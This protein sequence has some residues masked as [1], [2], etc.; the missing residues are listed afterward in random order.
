MS[1]QILGTIRSNRAISPP[2]V[3]VVI[4]GVVRQK[5]QTMSHWHASRWTRLA[6][7]FAITTVALVPTSAVSGEERG[8][9]TFE[10][11]D[12]VSDV[13]GR[14]E[15]TDPN[16]VNA[17]GL[18]A[19]PATPI[20]VAD[21]GTDVS[22][23]YRGATVSESATSVL[24]LV[25]NIPNGA[26]TGTVFN[27]TTGF[28]VGR[29]DASA[30]ALFLFSS[31]NGSIDGWAPNVP[32]MASTE[33]QSAV[34][35]PEAVYKG[36]AIATTPSGPRLYAANFHAGTVDVFDSSFTPIHDP[37]AFVDRR[38][39]HDY[40]PFN[41]QEL[42]GRLYV[43]Y[44]QQS[45]DR[46]DDVAGAGHGFVD[47][48]DTSGK[49][50]KR[51]ARSGRLNSPWGLALAPDS[52]GRFSHALLVGNF[53]DG[54]INA[55][56]ADTGAWLGQL[57]DEDHKPITIDGLWALRIGNSAF[58]GTESLVF[59]AGPDDEKHGLL[60]LISAQPENG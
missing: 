17:W 3:A 19:G 53:G 45:D 2:I 32:S 6:A 33:A 20:W 55:Y 24:P 31:E 27:G 8:G 29:D 40:A 43:T 58:G 25:V 50:L 46:H 5:G 15:V 57:R 9:T 51:L 37:G 23:L 52:F 56:N 28:V 22:T 16:L 60:G 42:N 26:P 14:A 4:C 21:N 34:T 49:L 36:L 12:L 7:G 30:P 41:V 13:P 59:S 18:S 10:R 35:V 44:A 1:C 48:F 39:P 47:V 38:L 11:S 54:R